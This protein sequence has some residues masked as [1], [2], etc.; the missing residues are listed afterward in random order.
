M[1]LSILAGETTI[2]TREKRNVFTSPYVTGALLA[3]LIFV[4]LTVG[5]PFPWMADDWTHLAAFYTK[6]NL[7][8]SHFQAWL[9]RVP[10]WAASTWIIFQF[11]SV[12]NITGP[13]YLFFAVH[14]AG[15]VLVTKFLLR[16]STTG[17]CDAKLRPASGH[18]IACLCITTMA[19]QPNS[20]EI[21]YWPTCMSYS[22]GAL[23]MGLGLTMTV[24]PLRYLCFVLSFLSY[25]TFFL[26]T[27]ALLFIEAQSHDPKPRPLQFWV[28][29]F[30]PWLSAALTTLAVRHIA[31]HYVG[32]YLHLISL[33]PQHVLQ[34]VQVA[35]KQLF[36][37]RFI[38]MRSNAFASTVQ[39]AV[40]A[41]C[42]VIL[43][44]RQRWR[45]VQWL[46]LCFV[47]TALYWLLAYSAIRSIYGTQIMFGAIVGCLAV[48]AAQQS[49]KAQRLIMILLIV[50]LASY[51]LQ[52][53]SIVGIKSHNAIV[54]AE[55]EADMA[56]AL[57][58]CQSPCTISYRPLNEGLMKDWVLP[59]SFWSSYLTYIRMKYAANKDVYFELQTE[60]N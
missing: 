2:P 27:L 10:V 18:F 4:L 52:I 9:S 17:K 36:Q 57:T 11:H 19:L 55:R 28:R 60:L 48:S 16:C 24:W 22:L 54:L 45:G 8:S 43:S 3:F 53:R 7:F 6:P 31:A 50:L 34:Q 39:F 46:L 56:A 44:R 41:I 23:L 40:L 25:E 32:T 29:T 37:V 30:T 49:H 1:K 51:V 20:F 14:V 26:P 5:R 13:L 15:I 59:E 47:S 21:T 33:S 58:S 35:G 12:T 38:F 42:L